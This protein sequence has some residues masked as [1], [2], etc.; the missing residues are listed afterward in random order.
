M[1]DIFRR[2]DG[3]YVYGTFSAPK[4]D[5]LNDFPMNERGA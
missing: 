2:I 1:S 4:V 5:L 3:K